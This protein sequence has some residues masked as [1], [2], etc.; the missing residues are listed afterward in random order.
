LQDEGVKAQHGQPKDHGLARALRDQNDH[1]E[2][3]EKRE[4]A[5]LAVLAALKK[6]VEGSDALSPQHD[7]HEDANQRDEQPAQRY[8]DVRSVT[9]RRKKSSKAEMDA[10]HCSLSPYPTPHAMKL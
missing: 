2:K 5:H 7:R 4:K 1:A 3:S 6:P 9:E 8:T 10:I